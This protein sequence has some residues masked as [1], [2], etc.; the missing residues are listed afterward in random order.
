MPLSGGRVMGG[1]VRWYPAMLRVVRLDEVI[2]PC[3]S[4]RSLEPHFLSIVERRVVLRATDIHAGRHVRRE[5]VWT[6]RRVG[7]EAGTVIRRHGG[8]TLWKATRR[9]ERQTSSEA[10]A[11]H[12]D[13]AV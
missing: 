1:S 3:T 12:T 4:E 9:N 6:L 7:R 8:N 2:Y 13:R 5:P 10:V 11:H